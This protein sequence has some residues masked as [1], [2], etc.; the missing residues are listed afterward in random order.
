MK[1]I[2]LYLI[3]FIKNRDNK[4][5]FFYLY[6]NKNLRLKSTYEWVHA[7]NHTSFAF[8]RVTRQVAALQSFQK[9]DDSCP[10]NNSAGRRSFVPASKN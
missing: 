2:F 7:L 6:L 3:Q 9:L 1:N 5:Y 10:G 8:L 4:N